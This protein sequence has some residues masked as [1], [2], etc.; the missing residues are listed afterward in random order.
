MVSSIPSECEELLISGYVLGNLSPAEAGLFA[1][2]RAENPEIEEKIL[3]LQTSLDVAYFPIEIDPPA[4]LKAK[5]IAANTQGNISAEKTSSNRANA[6]SSEG[7]KLSWG[8]VLTTISGILVLVLSLSNYWFW[9]SLQKASPD[10]SPPAEVTKQKIYALQGVNSPGKAQ[11]VVNPQRLNATLTVSNLD[12]LPPNK[13]YAL[14][15]VIGKEAPFTTDA[16]GAILT[17]VFQVD[18]DGAITKN[19]TVPRVHRDAQ[20]IQ[21][22]AITI[23]KAIAPQTHA[24]SILISTQ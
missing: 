14:W 5:I 19:I 13:V 20:L 3:E 9:Q 22:I 2:I 16:K 4:N 11:L 8:K 12:P 18:S 24:G 6:L 10:N 23:E 17:E 21:K 7:I 15:T 1:E